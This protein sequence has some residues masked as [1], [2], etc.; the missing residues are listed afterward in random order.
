[1]K[2][3]LG[4]T[5]AGGVSRD[6]TLSCDVATTVGD[7]AHALLD[8]GLFTGTNLEEFVALRRGRVTLLGAPN[9]GREQLLDPA[10][11]IGASGLQTGWQVTVTSEFGTNAPRPIPMHGTVEV[12]S[13]PQEGAMFSLIAGVNTIGREPQSRIVLDERSV[14]RRHAL[15]EIGSRVVLRDLGSANGIEAYGQRVEALSIERPTEVML[16]AVRVRITPI[17]VAMT[18]ATE[19]DHRHPHTRAPRVDP[20]FPTSTRE[21]PQP[22]QPASSSR[23]PLLAMLAP[24]M[25]GGAMF[26]VTR[27]PMSLMMVAFTPLM[28]IGSW[29]DNLTSSRRKLKRELRTFHET[30]ARERDELEMLRNEEVETRAGETPS[31]ADIAE[32]MHTRGRLLWA[33]RPEHRGF[34]ELRFG[35]GTLASRTRVE[36]PQRGDAAH[37]EWNALRSIKDEFAEVAP[38]PVL[39]RL[40]RCG[41]IGVAGD[42]LLASGFARALMLQLAGLHSPAEMV[43]TAFAGTERV[44]DE[45]EWLKWLPHV[46]PVGSPV[47]AWQLADD[48]NAATRLLIALESLIEQRRSTGTGGPTVR[49][50]LEPDDEAAFG[51][52]AVDRLPRIP[53]VVVLVL[54]SEIDE[55]HRGRLIAIAENGPDLGIHV[56]WVAT[57]IARVP[58][59]C[60]SYVELDGSAE[61][62]GMASFV[63]QGRSVKLSRI[64]YVDASLA[65]ELARSLAPVDDT[66]AR[67]LDESDL[68][69]SVNLRELHRVDLLG[70]AGP[71]L[72]SWHASGSIVSDW[73][74]GEEREPLRLAAVLGQGAEGPAEIDLRLH[75]PHALVG[76]TTGAGKSEFLQSWIMSLAAN[77]SPDRLTFLLVDYKGGA[78]FAECVD[79]PHTV[80]LVTDLSPHLVRRALTSL[81]AE[82]RYREEL[83]AEHGA[84]DLLT[85]ERRSDAAAPPALVIVIDEFAALASEMPEFVDGVID[86]A[87]RGRSLGLH[88]IMAT[89]RPAG[90]I[91]DNLRANTNLRVALR[92]AD[93]ADSADVIGVKDAAF[94]D[95]ETPGRGAIKSGAGRIAHFQTGYLG[96]RATKEIPISRIE[97]RS[98][99]FVEGEAWDIP[100]TRTRGLCRPNSETETVRD[101]EQLRDGIIAAAELGGLARPR[102]PW[103]EMLPTSLSF[104]E[105]KAT[106]RGG[107]RHGADAREPRGSGEVLVGVRDRP[108]AQ[109]QEAAFIDLGEA[110]NAVILGASGTGKTSALLSF[111]ASFSED[112]AADPVHLYAID[113]AGGG[114]DPLIVLPT[115]GAVAP[116][117]DGELVRRVLRHLRSTVI[118]RGIRFSAA[119]ANDL[120][121]YRRATGEREPRVVLLIDGFS[122]FRQTTEMLGMPDSPMQLLGEIMQA[123]RAVGV[124]VVLTADRAGALPGLLAASVQQQLVLRLAS[125]NDYAYS[126]VPRDIFEMAGPGRA[127]F[128]GQED[129][130]QLALAGGAPDLLGLAA[131]LESLGSRLVDRDLVGVPL[132]RNAPEAIAMSELPTEVAGR[133]VYGIEIDDFE[134]IGMPTAGLGVIAGPAGSGL[135][136]AALTCASAFARWAEQH[137]EATELVLLTFAPDDGGGL[138]GRAEW[139]RV[140][141]GAEEVAELARE[142]T[143]GLGGKVPLASGAFSTGLIGMTLGGPM[144]AEEPGP[145]DAAPAFPPVTKRGVIVVERPTEAEGT[146]ALPILVALAKAARRSE[147]LVLFEF[148]QGGAAGV[149]DLFGALK[150]PRWGLA[151]QPDEGDGGS[152]FREGFGRVKRADFPPGRGFAVDAGRSTPIHVAL[153]PA[154]GVRTAADAEIGGV[155]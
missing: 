148:E 16:G 2:L 74:R 139:D 102:K 23:I 43:I 84:K 48:P 53:A 75:G 9:N 62:I 106:L 34:L 40:D 151:L 138:G 154:S 50:H 66:A 128:G 144:P 63:R 19:L 69:R 137:D 140:A 150:Q 135:S 155:S 95:A 14:S 29:I 1:M 113:A 41:S 64:E 125:P 67:M 122:S 88:L 116:M 15:I 86:V 58:A 152:P 111:A 28:M 110:G 38:V 22:P 44:A 37:D 97:I 146:E 3:K 73:R 42:T 117:S 142:L 79:L 20:R 121:A 13:G 21:L 60:R 4:V 119:R 100:G 132:V 101:I 107:G 32:A 52:D 12:L 68:P 87:Q 36:L 105:A 123:G 27:S 76:G 7:A 131:A 126:D 39:E 56:I 5:V 99:G 145:R 147:A 17:P 10:A 35:D 118:D 108:D 25:M 89:Q 109:L 104:D 65:S 98:L 114:L 80:G 130:V 90:V 30:L 91:K 103:L 18:G 11:P 85:M 24:M 141:R 61:T 133:P 8:T 70:G 82:L 129:E 81:R 47:A 149:W 33:R 96:G 134:P 49:S 93:E 71:I 46:D 143:V 26:A 127:V 115:V 45:W 153:P 51:D 78:A 54:E 92:M 31:L 83:L 136:T 77:V 124:H 112:A 57:D 94:F 120:R 55:A 59:A 72:Q 6:I